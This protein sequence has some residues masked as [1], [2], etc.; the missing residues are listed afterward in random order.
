MKSP[1]LYSLQLKLNRYKLSYQLLDDQTI[2][3]GGIKGLKSLK[4]YYI[5]IPLF[6]GLT[7]VGIGLG[8][9]FILFEASGAVFLLYAAYGASVVKR[10]I[11]LNK[12]IKIIKNGELL[13]TQDKQTTTLKP[14]NITDYKISIELVGKETYEGRLTIINSDNTEFFILGLFDT[15]KK[16]LEEDLDYISEYIKFKMNTTNI[17]LS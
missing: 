2:Q 10:K 7:I 9:D 3:L 1:N 17:E 8:L 16:M 15:D 11:A 5:F 12:D 14:K 4:L 13:L 6:I